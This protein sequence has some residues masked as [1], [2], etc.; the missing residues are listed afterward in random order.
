MKFFLLIAV[1]SACGLFASDHIDGPVTTKHAVSDLTDLYAF[2]SPSQPGR[3]TL[4]LN[5]RPMALSDSHFSSQ[6]EYRFLLREA[7]VVPGPAGTL[8][9]RTRDTDERMI[10]IRF[11]TPEDHARHTATCDA[12]NGKRRTVELNVV[13]GQPDSSG[14]LFY[15]GL[16][17][18]PFFFNSSWV[19]RLI[20]RGKVISPAKANTMK[21]LNVLSL[22]VELDLDEL[23]GRKVG[24][25]AIAA[26]SVALDARGGVAASLDRIGRAEVTNIL[27]R[28]MRGDADLRDSYNLERPFRVN[29]AHGTAYLERFTR[30]LR[31]Y[32]GVDGKMDWNEAQRGALAAMLMEDHLII[33]AAQA[34]SSSPKAGYLGIEKNLLRGRRSNAVGGRALADDFMDELFNFTINRN[35]GLQI[36]DGIR[37]PSKAVSD[38]FPY[39]AEPDRSV[40]GWL[41]AQLGRLGTGSR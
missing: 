14:L 24:L 27:L 20:S 1:F 11:D 28:S 21:R 39:L 35:T 30:N 17:S 37:A 36:S 4:V 13:D 40:L 32:D 5:V 41:K 34:R 19:G 12:G 26:Q 6:V 7:A 33:N 38:V 8:K 23:F 2:P 3:W 25:I 10:R 16:R 31:F 15:H 22:V 29:A 9:L 18:D